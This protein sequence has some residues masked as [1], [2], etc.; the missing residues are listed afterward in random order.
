MEAVSAAVHAQSRV[1]SGVHLVLLDL[2]FVGVAIGWP[3]D[4]AASNGRLW[5]KLAGH[6][7]GGEQ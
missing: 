6:L 5:I 7:T 2:D 4:V 3:R 1:A